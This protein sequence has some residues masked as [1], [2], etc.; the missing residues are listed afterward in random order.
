MTRV[1]KPAI[2]DGRQA[3]ERTITAQAEDGLRAD[4]IRGR[5][6][7]EISRLASE[8]KTPAQHAYVRS[9]A[10]STNALLAD[11][12]DLDRPEPDRRP[13]AAHPDPR[14]AARGWQTGRHCIFERISSHEPELEAG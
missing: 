11:L 3:A 2:R 9:Y 13:G 7:D 12:R 10:A 4:V 14:L 8:A 1:P 6:E 5:Q